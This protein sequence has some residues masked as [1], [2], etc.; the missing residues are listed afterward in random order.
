MIGDAADM[1]ARLRRL[2]PPWFGSES[3]V[4]DALLAGAAQVLAF[5]YGLYAY[6]KLQTRLATATD[7]WLDFAGMDFFGR[8]PRFKGELDRPYSRRIR[9]E[10]FRDRVTRHAYDRA[11][12]DITGDHPE[13]FEAWRPG[14]CGGYG[15]PGLALGRVG[16]WGSRTTPFEVIVSTPE[17]Q[18]YG[19][20]ERGGWGSGVG[21][22]GS[23]NFSFV[24]DADTVG[25]GPTQADVL[26]AIERVR[27]AGITAYVRFTQLGDPNP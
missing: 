17:L 4:V 16:R 22:Y 20:P 6:A 11:V 21:G 15:A 14:C 18:N 23:G 5:S 8:F 26:A 7:A 9:L 3:P 10:V 1:E 27:A 24:D 2:L 12:F 25:S 19:I 13:V